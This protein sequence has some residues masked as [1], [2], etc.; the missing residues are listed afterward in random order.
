MV[1]ECDWTIFFG[2]AV[3]AV[4]ALMCRWID[5]RGTMMNTFFKLSLSATGSI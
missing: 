1:R 4:M 5:F 2:E 3:T